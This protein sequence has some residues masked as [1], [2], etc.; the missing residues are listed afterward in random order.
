MTSI[1]RQIIGSHLLAGAEITG[2]AI[3]LRPDQVLLQDTNGPMSFLQLEAL[4]SPRLRVPRVVAYVDHNVQQVDCRNSDDH[5][6]L[7]TASARYGAIVSKA[8]NG[9]CHQVH[10]ETFS[11][12]GEV[13]VGT[14]SHTV[15]CGA[16]GM[17]A[18][19]AGSME[20]AVAMGTGAY[21][22]AMPRIVRIWLTGSLRPWVTAKDVVLELLRRF[23]VHGGR[24]K[25]FEFD[26]PGVAAL[27]VPQRAT[28]A[29]MGAELGLTTTV[30]PSDAVTRAYFE[31]LGREAE[32]R[33]VRAGAD[34]A[35]DETI[36]LDLSSIGVLVALPSSP[37]RVVP[38][39]EAVGTPLD[40]VIVGSCTNGSWED[41]YTVARIMRG[42]QVHPALS[43][44]LFPGSRRV[45]EAMAREGLTADLLTAGIQ[46][47]GASCGAC[48]GLSHVPA[49]GTRSLRTF[50]RNF[51]GRSGTRDDAVYLCS[52]AVAAASAIA[53]AI[54]DPRE[55]G[56]PPDVVPPGSLRSSPAGLV[57]NAA[58]GAASGEPTAPAIRGPHM[59]PVPIGQ[60][61]EDELIVHVVLKVADN[62]STDHISPVGVEALLLRTNIPA[63]AAHSFKYLDP[64][65]ATRAKAHPN[66]AIVAGAHYGQG[67]S[68]ETAASGLMV[69]GVRVILARSFA[70]IHQANL[71]NWGIVPL[72]LEPPAGY[73]ALEQGDE[74][75]ITGLRG[76]LAS[77]KP[78]TVVNL[79]T[80]AAIDVACALSPRERDIVLAGGVLAQAR[81]AVAH[82]VQ[83]AA[84][85]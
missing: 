75:Q 57:H 50:N 40:Q 70:R 53:G 19:G 82:A 80:G 54:A 78:L 83:T 38:I 21:W 68:R 30:F 24:G 31:L 67:S 62:I 7:E 32:W 27:T 66:N 36:E 59:Q 39:E 12:P 46:I 81:A 58:P 77:G 74:L 25:V 22:L 4:G 42:K 10:L 35:Y 23:S 43:A 14:D 49:S 48:P 18:F 65:F 76:L 72:Q 34:A 33:P 11:V 3:Q 29:N 44:V 2:E 8:G 52:P 51:P 56:A 63:I 55:L 71:V 60:A 45:M 47:A 17:L 37:D 1:T 64:T 26:G 13:L 28:I 84:D 85:S 79:R 6:Y 41:M 73:D 5:R 61:P 16:V 69:L 20:V 9:I 15:L